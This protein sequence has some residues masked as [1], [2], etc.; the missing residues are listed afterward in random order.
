MKV[1]IL[2]IIFV[3]LAIA[4]VAT[5]YARPVHEARAS[6]LLSPCPLGTK[7]LPPRPEYDA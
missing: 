5:L 1:V 6:M 3:M 2:A 7:N 4:T